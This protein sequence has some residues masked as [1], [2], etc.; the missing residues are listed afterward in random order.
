MEKILELRKYLEIIIKFIKLSAKGR[1]IFLKKK[2]QIFLFEL[3]LI[4]I[5]MPKKQ[6]RT[7]T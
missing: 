7:R 1:R 3:L 4:R 2:N 5:K 6:V